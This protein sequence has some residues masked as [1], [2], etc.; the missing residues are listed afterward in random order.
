MMK[1]PPI[2]YDNGTETMGALTKISH[3]LGEK[4]SLSELGALLA[5]AGAS[6]LYTQVP[7]TLNLRKNLGLLV[8]AGIP[9]GIGFLTGNRALRYATYGA[10]LAHLWY[11]RGQGLTYAVNKRYIWSYDGVPTTDMA[12]EI[13]PIPSRMLV[14][15][16][17]VI[18]YP[19]SDLP[20]AQ[21]AAMNDYIPKTRQLNDGRATVGANPLLRSGAP[22][23]PNVPLL[24]GGR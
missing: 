23:S 1:K 21:P 24:A 15:G 6:T 19:P 7:T 4:G 3:S 22:L 8:A 12:D 11:V 2:T 14:Q 13:A 17:E 16:Q 5:A 10:L 20:A 9:L 18:G